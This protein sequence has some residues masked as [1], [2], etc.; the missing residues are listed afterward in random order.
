[1][2]S[3]RATNS[4]NREGVQGLTRMFSRS[5]SIGSYMNIGQ[6]VMLAPLQKWSLFRRPPWKLFLH[7][8]LL[9]LTTAYVLTIRTSES[10]YLRSMDRTWRAFLFPS[11]YSFTDGDTSVHLASVKELFDSLDSSV[12][13]YYQLTAI[14]VPELRL[15]GR[16]IPAKCLNTSASLRDMG[17]ILPPTLKVERFENDEY[18]IE[19]TYDLELDVPVATA[20]GVTLANASQWLSSVRRIRLSFIACN[21]CRIKYAGF[22]CYVWSVQAW[23]ELISGAGAELSVSHHIDRGGDT[24][25]DLPSF[26]EYISRTKGALELMVVLVASILG[27]LLLRAVWAAGRVYQRTR[28]SHQQVRASWLMVDRKSWADNV[29]SRHPSTPMA[30]PVGLF[31]KSFEALEPPDVSLASG[32][33]LEEPQLPEVTLYRWD[34]LPFSVRR[35]FFPHWE[36]FALVAVAFTLVC[37]VNNLVVRADHTVR[38]TSSKLA[39]GFQLLLLWWS[40]VGFLKPYPQLYTFV[41][42]LRAGM[43]FLFSC[44]CGAIPPFMAFT[45]AGAALFGDQVE[46]FKTIRQTS[47]TI[48]S[49]FN[50]DSV[51]D[52]FMQL[53]R[54]FPV[55]GQIYLYLLICFFMYIVLNTVVATIEEAFFNSRSFRRSL[56][57]LIQLTIKSH[58]NG[59]VRKTKPEDFVDGVDKQTDGTATEDQGPA[60]PPAKSSRAADAPVSDA[61]FWGSSYAEFVELLEL[62]DDVSIERRTT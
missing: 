40:F 30:A 12:D 28:A 6:K 11:D 46:N 24:C 14:A 35:R 53:E 59:F 15:V 61:S 4:G 32:A 10:A 47:A 18:P 36:V 13:N 45:F 1:M 60:S 48:F 51:L 26:G 43:R 56:Q 44:C 5:S 49:V 8:V 39:W 16:E 29:M 62:M 3:T 54:F 34:E 37:F 20:F 25:E 57:P 2:A 27:L 42:T 38:T 50:G 19:T 41:L 22:G 21:D 33:P 7:V 17:A 9:V 55:S 31:T 58:H 23:Y 52:V